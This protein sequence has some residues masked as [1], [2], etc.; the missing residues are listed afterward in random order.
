FF[1][2]DPRDDALVAVSPRHFVADAELALARDE[3]FHLLDDTGIDLVAAFD[4]VHRAITLEFQLRE[5]VSVGSDDL[6]I[7][8][9]YRAGID[10]DV[11][12]NGREYQ[13]QRLHE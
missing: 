12:V 5:L 3:N 9:P 1:R 2:H 7:F 4:A 8:V 13:R 11:I 10:Y 6:A